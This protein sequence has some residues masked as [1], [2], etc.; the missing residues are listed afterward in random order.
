MRYKNKSAGTNQALVLHGVADGT[1]HDDQNHNLLVRSST[2]AACGAARGDFCGKSTR[3]S[4]GLRRVGSHDFQPS[5][6]P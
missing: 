3:A 4:I 1:T 6:N 5:R 2:G